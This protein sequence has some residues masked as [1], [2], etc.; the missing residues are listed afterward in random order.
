MRNEFDTMYSGENIVFDIDFSKKLPDFSADIDH[1]MMVFSNLLSNSLDAM[2]LIPQ[3]TIA[4]RAVEKEGKIIIRWHDTGP[5]I[6]GEI[7]NKIFNPDFT[8][9]EDGK[10]W[11]MGLSTARDIMEKHGGYIS[12]DTT[13]RKGAT[14]V[15][16]LPKA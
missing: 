4:V 5:G 9:K 14:F 2:A 6:Y 13:I 1:L 12:L 7:Q 15:L 11:G 8:T 3:G 10:G 16:T